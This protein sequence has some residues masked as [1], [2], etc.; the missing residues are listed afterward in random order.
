MPDST[1]LR[2]MLIQGVFEHWGR[3]KNCANSDCVTPYF[4]AKRTDQTVCNAE[5]CKAEKQR[6]HA[7]NWW[8][9]N[10]ARKEK[11]SQETNVAERTGRK[12]VSKNVV[13]KA[14]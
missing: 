6:E 1:A 9:A 8:N 5:I 10:R 4:I 12:G 3:F 11:K 2:P 14:R 7:R 13:K